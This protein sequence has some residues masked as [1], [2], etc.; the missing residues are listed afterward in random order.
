MASRAGVTGRVF[1]GVLIAG[2]ACA[3]AISRGCEEE[4][5]GDVAV[6]KIGGRTFHLELALDPQTRFK[7]LSG[8]SFIEP[9][10]GLLFVFPDPAPMHFVM[11][12]CSIPIDI[13]FLDPTGRVIAMHEMQPEP[14]RS[15]EE[16]KLSPP[17]FNPQA[18]EWTWMNQAYEDR[19]KKYPSDF[20]SQF[21]IELAGGTIKN[22]GVKKQ[23]KI[24]LDADTLKRRA[25]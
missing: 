18:P 8:R 5:A 11:R 6:V 2:A 25:Q 10:G 15:E 9:D 22:L 4:A 20:D 21:A 1:A 19:L 12:D 23:D 24:A 7:G 16:K 3:F 17:A 13:L 14:A